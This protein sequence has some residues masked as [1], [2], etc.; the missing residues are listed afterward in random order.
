[1][2]EELKGGGSFEELAKK[3][4]IARS[5]K[6]GGRLGWLYKGKMEPELE[7]VAFGLEKEKHSNVIQTEKGYQIIKVLDTSDKRD[8]GLEEAKKKIR[9]A[10][11][12]KKKRELVQDYY[13]AAKV[14]RDPVEKGVLVKVGDEAFT[15]EALAPILAK[16]SEKEKEKVKER[17]IRYFIETRVF[18]KEAKKIGLE[19]DPGVA[20]E[21]ERKREEVLA[22]A[23]RQQFITDKFPIHEDDI[24]SYYETH[25]EEFRIPL[26]VRV[27][28]MLVETEQQAE[29]ILTALKEGAVFTQLAMKRSASGAGDVGW[30]GKGEKDPAL[31]KAAFSLEKGQISDIIKAEAGYEIIKVVDKKGGEVRPLEEIKQLLRMRLRKERFEQEKERYYKKAGVKIFAQA[32]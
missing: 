19:N 2:L 9:I 1:M 20:A 29:E 31:E 12:R 24:E 27:E 22:K 14:N 15:E 32:L 3:K 28:S 13:K 16:V 8:I 30:F 26:R 4:S 23:F 5:W 17:W 10:L 11:A 7:K 21:L 6:K 18:S 25:Q